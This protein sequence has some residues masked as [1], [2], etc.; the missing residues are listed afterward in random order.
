MKIGKMSAVPPIMLVYKSQA[1]L[2]AAMAELKRSL[3]A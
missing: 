2:D 1:E 3:K